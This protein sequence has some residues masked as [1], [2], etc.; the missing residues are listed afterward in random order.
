[1]FP[2]SDVQLR[3]CTTSDA[4]VKFDVV[5]MRKTS[6]DRASRNL[7]FSQLT[8]FPGS[9]TPY[10]PPTTGLTNHSQSQGK[11]TGLIPRPKAG[12]RV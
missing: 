7:T 5:Q 3:I 4:Q 1:M 10:Q 12:L 11:A 6:A 2:S 8:P 9:D